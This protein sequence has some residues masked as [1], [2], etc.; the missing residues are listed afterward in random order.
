MSKRLTTR[1]FIEKA[2]KVHGNRYDY[3]KTKYVNSQTKII[4]ICPIHGEFRQTPNNHLAGYNCFKCSGNKKLTT[5]DFIKRAKRIH[6]NKYNYFKVKYI[7]NETKVKIICPIHGEF[8]QTPNHHLNRKQGC[9][10]C[11]GKEVF[12]KKQFINKAIKIHDNKYDYSLVDYTN[13]KIDIKII[14]PDHGMFRQSSDR[15]LNRKQGCP[16]CI[17]KVSSYEKE[18]CSF[19]DELKVDYKQS[20]RSI[21]KGKELD[22]LIPSFNLAIEFNGIYWHSEQVLKNKNSTKYHQ[23]KYL[24]CKKKG[25]QLLSIFEPEWVFKKEIIK[26]IICSKLNIYET[27]IGARKCKIKQ[28]VASQ[29]RSFFDEN[30]IQGFV[31]GRHIGLYYKNQL[32]SAISFSKNKLDYELVR[33]VNK[34]NTLVHGAFSKLLKYFINNN[35]FNKIY[36]FADLRYFEGSVY[37][38]NGFKFVHEVA[39][40]Y[41]YFKGLELLHKRNFQHKRLKE[42]FENYDPKLTEY[43]N[44]LNNGYYRIWDCGKIKFEII[45]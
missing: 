42:K 4:I 16:K 14:C 33:F 29:A 12:S 17:S 30:H 22:I 37:L 27:K 20:D 10:Y 31:G 44:C 13:A 28:L 3:S 11:S 43:Q 35:N 5:E 41:Y 21:L 34:K 36:T 2:I 15:H 23:Q 24:S 6:G 8:R 40:S 38:K 18:I 25:Y 32:V 19:L 45:K 1:Q 26:S 9:L 7:N 39:P